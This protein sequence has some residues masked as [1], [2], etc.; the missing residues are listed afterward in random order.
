SIVVVLPA[1]FGPS[2]PKHSPRPTANDSPSTAMTSAYRLTRSTQRTA[3]GGTG[4]IVR[5]RRDAGVGGSERQ[6]PPYT[7]TLRLFEDVL[8]AAPEHVVHVRVAHA[9][10]ELPPFAGDEQIMLLRGVPPQREGNGAEP[11]RRE[12]LAV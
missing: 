5:D 3:G 11:T 7:P 9:V 1:P 10:E 8:H 4:G 6:D 12:D 2:S